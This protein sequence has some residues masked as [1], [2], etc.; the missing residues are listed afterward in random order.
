MLGSMSSQSPTLSPS[1]RLETHI[2]STLLKSVVSIKL[3]DCSLLSQSLA[4]LKVETSN[5]LYIFHLSVRLLL[6]DP[7][8]AIETKR[9]RKQLDVAHS[10]SVCPLQLL[11]GLHNHPATQFLA[12]QCITDKRSASQK[13]TSIT[14]YFCSA[15]GVTFDHASICEIPSL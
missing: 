7:T 8:R 3:F 10:H 6:Q 2:Y 5:M 13:K 15:P 1:P 9:S 14:V 12:P 11:H 4:D